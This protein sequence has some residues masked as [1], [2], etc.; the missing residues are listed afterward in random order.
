MAKKRLPGVDCISLFDQ[1]NQ[2]AI[3][4]EAGK[5]DRLRISDWQRFEHFETLLSAEEKLARGLPLSETESDVLTS[6]QHRTGVPEGEG[7]SADLILEYTSNLARSSYE[8]LK[9]GE[10]LLW[11]YIAERQRPGSE[12]RARTEAYWDRATRLILA[13]FAAANPSEDFIRD[14][15]RVLV[16]NH[17]AE[18]PQ[19]RQLAIHLQGPETSRVEVDVDPTPAPTPQ[20]AGVSRA[21]REHTPYLLGKDEPTPVAFADKFLHR[22]RS[23]EGY[24]SFGLWLRPGAVIRIEEVYPAETPRGESP[25]ATDH[26]Y[27]N[28]HGVAVTLAYQIS[29]DPADAFWDRE[30][31][32]PYV[33]ST[34]SDAS[35]RTKGY[36]SPTVFE[37]HPLF[38]VPTTNSID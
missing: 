28:K 8:S 27:T 29:F 34:A 33:V 13:A 5:I 36:A 15:I 24:D 10:R 3:V 9:V 11:R 18:D 21:L 16:Q 25:L 1:L 14:E 32:E 26:I 23:E 31:T 37:R 30:M 12:S 35:G 2:A 7:K 4:S 22:Y 20:R 17:A 19:L 38:Q 6:L